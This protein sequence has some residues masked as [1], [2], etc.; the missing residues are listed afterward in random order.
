LELDDYH[1]LLQA[2][3]QLDEEEL[4]EKIKDQILKLQTQNTYE[5]RDE[6]QTAPRKK[7]S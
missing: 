7:R 2:P 3:N 6:E 5:P 4:L 1:L